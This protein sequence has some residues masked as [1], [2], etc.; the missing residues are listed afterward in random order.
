[1]VVQNCA[2]ESKGLSCNTNVVA[3]SIVPAW[4]T[5][6]MLT[7][8]VL[9]R[10]TSGTLLVAV[11]KNFAFSIMSG[12]MTLARELALLVPGDGAGCWPY[13][14]A[15]TSGRRWTASPVGVRGLNINSS[16]EANNR[17]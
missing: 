6:H 15:G 14:K 10:V 9:N 5:G 2:N 7:R 4:L 1:M 11:M 3:G 17:Q 12:V 8:G 13:A 16:T